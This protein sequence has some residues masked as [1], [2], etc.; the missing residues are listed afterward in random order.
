[1]CSITFYPSNWLYNAGVIGLLVVMEA[2]G[3]NPDQMIQQKEGTVVLLSKHSPEEIFEQWKAMSPTGCYG[4]QGAYYAN[5]T[6]GSIKRR[7]EALLQSAPHKSG[8]RKQRQF[9]CCFCGQKVSASRSGAAF[10]TQAFGNKLLGS[11]RTFSNM[12]WTNEAR[13]FVCPACEFVLMCHHLAFVPHI[14]SRAD[15]LSVF[16]NSPSLGVSYHLNRLLRSLEKIYSERELGTRHLL[17]MSITE[18]AVKMSAAMGVWTLLN[19]EMIVQHSRGIDFLSLPFEVVRLLADRRIATLLSRIGEY[20]VYESLI[21]RKTSQLVELSY[22]L[23]RVGVKPA[24]ERSKAEKEYLKRALHLER[25]RK[26]PIRTAEEILH[27]CAICEEN[28]LRRSVH[29]LFRRS[30]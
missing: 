23:L 25:N 19:V 27:L 13:D 12:Y 21:E 26:Y 7:I 22:N 3:E 30:L 4:K 20:I 17:A 18:Y 14:G 8:G 16:I 15:S 11:Q 5:Q 2:L 9:S 24:S 28:R 6:E 10:L 1:M 29:E